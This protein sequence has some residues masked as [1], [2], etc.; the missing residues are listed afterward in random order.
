MEKDLKGNDL[1]YEIGDYVYYNTEDKE[2]IGQIDRICSCQ[3]CQDRGFLEPVAKNEL[4]AET[5]ITDLAYK[6]GF[7]DYI[8]SKKP[9]TNKLSFDNDI[10]NKVLEFKVF[11]EIMEQLQKYDELSEQVDKISQELCKDFPPLNIF[12]LAEIPITNVIKLLKFIFNDEGNWS[13][14]DYFIYELEYGKKYKKG[15]YTDENGEEIKLGT[16]EDLYNLL[17]KE[18]KNEI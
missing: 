1:P 9:P 4:G 13:N 16:I 7:K 8:F 6:N 3:K 5:W 18:I 14:I 15:C 2:Y 11:K 10:N 12:G 17:I